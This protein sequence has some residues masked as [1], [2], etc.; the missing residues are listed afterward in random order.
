[1]CHVHCFEL[2]LYLGWVLATRRCTLL[3]NCRAGVPL[4]LLS[5]ILRSSPDKNNIT[6]C[7][8]YLVKHAHGQ[9]VIYNV[10]IHARA[11]THIHAR[12]RTHKHTHAHIHTHAHTQTYT[13]A[14]TAA[15][16][17]THARAHTRTHTYIHTY[18]TYT[19]T[20]THTY[21]NV[22]AQTHTHQQ[23]TWQ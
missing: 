5:G 9:S 19:S 6:F 14:H 4:C 17:H 1:M 8:L 15:Q 2:A 3:W 21:A 11:H 22:H 7:R 10:R 23:L 20:R 16:T 12:T 18:S 13:N